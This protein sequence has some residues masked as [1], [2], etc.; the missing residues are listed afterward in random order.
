MSFNILEGV[1][2][3]LNYPPL[4]K[5]DPNTQEVPKTKRSE[6]TDKFGQAA[7]PAV[8]TGLYRFVQSDEGAE[9]VLAPGRTVNW[10]E[11]IFH[12]HKKEVIERIA[13]YASVPQRVT[14]RSM[15][16]IAKESIKMIKERL[17]DATPKELKQFFHNQINIILAY[18][19]A[20]VHT[21]EGLDYSALD[22][23]INKMKG[24]ISSLVQGI[25]TVFSNPVSGK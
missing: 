7:I 4:Q 19:P 22:D 12:E 8:L 25:G 21:G 24:P 15:N 20:E 10:I 6:T 2:Q 17:H 1:R 18:L 5:I 3:S 11:K 23:N 16:V 9:E 13:A 14:A